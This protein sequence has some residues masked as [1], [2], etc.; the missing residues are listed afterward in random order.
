VTAAEIDDLLLH[1]CGRARARLQPDFAL[2]PRARASA[3]ALRAAF[4]VPLA[5]QRRC[6]WDA[7]AD[8]LAG[9]PEVRAFIGA[10]AHSSVLSVLRQLGFG[11]RRLVR[12]AA[13]TQGRMQV[14]LLAA[15][16][17][18]TDGR[19]SSSPRRAIST[20]APSI[21]SI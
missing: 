15:A 19:R 4:N 21:R 6:G 2:S 5:E 9:A 1:A 10:E 7:E 12:I 13:D 20:R 17:A 18:A 14:P 8:G 11:E 16:L 3:A